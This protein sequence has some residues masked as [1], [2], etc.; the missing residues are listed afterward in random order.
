MLV[1]AQKQ[2]RN[3]QTIYSLLNTSSLIGGV[4]LN[5]YG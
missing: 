5:A 1:D 3:E 2:R 4:V